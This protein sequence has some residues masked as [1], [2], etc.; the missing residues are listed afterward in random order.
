M[1]E[2]S[3]LI[4]YLLPH[5]VTAGAYSAQVQGEVSAHEAKKG[6]TIFHHALSDADL[7]IQ[8]YFE[9]VLLARYPELNFFS[10]EQDKSLNRKY[11]LG[12]SNLEVLVDP[13]DG[14]RPYIDGRENYQIIVAIHDEREM[15]GAVC[16]LPRREKCFVATKGRGAFVLSREEILSGKVGTSLEVSVS[17]GPVLVFN[18]PSLVEKLS[19]SLDVKDLMVSYLEEPGRHSS[20]DLLDGLASAVV[21]ETCQAIDGGALA[22]IAQEAGAIV[23]SFTGEPVGSYRV[24]DSRTQPHVVVAATDL[25]YQKVLAALK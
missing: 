25:V 23:S 22:F 11:F 7:T 6:A 14:T 3:A 12:T 5:I 2:V 19:P 21:H 8:A 4:S 9:V 10:E 17:Q 13:V 15:I 16:Y 20:T 24:R 18:S 1:I